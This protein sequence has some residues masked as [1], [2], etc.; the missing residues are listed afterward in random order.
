MFMFTYSIEGVRHIPR[1]ASVNVCARLQINC[2][3]QT[4]QKAYGLMYQFVRLLG[5]NLYYH[6]QSGTS[7]NVLC[8]VT[9]A[10]IKFK[11]HRK[12]TVLAP[13]HAVIEMSI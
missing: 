2:F 11:G 8:A 3:M 4:S 7:E 1:L 9:S 6:C 10:V 12:L 13:L 5:C